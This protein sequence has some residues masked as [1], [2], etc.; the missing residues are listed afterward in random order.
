[1]N[2]QDDF[3]SPVHDALCALLLIAATAS[4]HAAEMEVR[5]RTVASDG[6]ALA[7]V[8]IQAFRRGE[9]SRAVVSGSNGEYIVRLPPGPPITRIEYRHTGL[10]LAEIVYVSGAEPQHIVKVLYRP[11]EPRN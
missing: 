10:D 3:K 1:M 7:G 9:V 5:G 2:L 4:G 6:Q 8:S 11:G